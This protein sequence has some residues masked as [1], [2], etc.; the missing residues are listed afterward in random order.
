MISRLHVWR[1]LSK[2]D[3]LPPAQVAQPI[4]PA[5]ATLPAT[6]RIPAVTL[7]DLCYRFAGELV[8]MGVVP[9]GL[10]LAWSSGHVEGPVNRRKLIKRTMCGRA[11]LDLLQQRVRLRPVRS[12]AVNVAHEIG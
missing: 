6:G 9:A 3:N 4:V 8:D 5:I 2:G 10:S 7:V 12:L 1:R 11:K